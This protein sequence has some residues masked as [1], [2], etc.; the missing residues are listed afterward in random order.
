MVDGGEI[1]ERVR[2]DRDQHA[3]RCARRRCDLEIVRSARSA[4]AS[5]V[6][7]QRGVVAGDVDVEGDDVEG[8]ED[9]VDGGRARWSASASATPPSDSDAVIA[10]IAISAPSGRI[11]ASMWRQARSR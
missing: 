7:Q 5:C 2:V 6:S 10:A 11:V 3:A 1:A 8:G 9:H 4:G